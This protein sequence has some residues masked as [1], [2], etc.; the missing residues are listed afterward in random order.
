[1]RANLVVVLAILSIPVR[2]PAAG[3]PELAGKALAA[4]YTRGTMQRRSDA[5]FEDARNA[6]VEL[7]RAWS[8]GRDLWV[9][10]KPEGWTVTMPVYD[11]LGLTYPR[12]RLLAPD[13]ATA[14]AHIRDWEVVERRMLADRRTRDAYQAW[15]RGRLSP[16]DEELLD[17]VR[18]GSSAVRRHL[19]ELKALEPGNWEVLVGLEISSAPA[20]VTVQGNEVMVSL[21]FLRR[22]GIAAR[23]TA[24]GV[25][26]DTGKRRCVVPRTT[27]GWLPVSALLRDDLCTVMVHRPTQTVRITPAL[28]GR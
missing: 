7:A 12:S 23:D 3:L 6:T 2:C 10:V 19:A 9:R 4:I 13:R 8:A 25:A 26:L 15:L 1:M 14:L 24:D 21:P 17:M 18:L 27:A 20:D 11:V 28:P 5:R 16:E 22:G